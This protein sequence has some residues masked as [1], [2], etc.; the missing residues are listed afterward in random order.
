VA[1]PG[2]PEKDNDVTLRSV[3]TPSHA[4]RE[5]ASSLAGLLATLEAREAALLFSASADVALVI[6]ADGSVG[7]GVIAS[8]EL[9]ILKVDTWPGRGWSEV[10]TI[11]SRP[12]IEQMIQEAQL[13]LPPRWR[14]INHQIPNEADIPVRYCLLKAGAGGQFVA[15]GRDMRNLAAVQQRLLAAEQSIEQEYARLRHAE[16]RYRLLMQVASEAIIVVDSRS[17]RIME[18]NAAA[19]NLVSKPMKRLMG[20]Q[21][22]SLFDPADQEGVDAVM[23]ALRATG[24]AD[25]VALTLEGGKQQAV[26]SATIFRQETATCYL[27]RLQPIAAGASGIVISRAQAGVMNVIR[28]MPEPF[29]VTDLDRRIVSAN[30]AFLDSAQLGSEEQARGEPVER[31]L[32]RAGVDISV[33]FNSLAEKGAV[34]QFQTMLRGQFGAV[35]DVEV[36][37]VASP[38]GNPSCY[39]F[40]IRRVNRRATEA[41]PGKRSLLRSVEEMTKLVGKVPLKDLVREATDIIERLCI[42]AALQLND[43]NRASTADMLGLS[44]QSL[45]VK[46]HRY[47]IEDKDVGGDSA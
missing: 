10:S 26:L 46:L 36:S 2:G 39:G 27:M 11:E 38:L 25:D 35:E 34:R 47:G 43:N 20:L 6:N 18:S 30:A 21:F 7:E 41:E 8:S 22:A 3:S 28:D 17:G 1:L 33:L 40:S 45:Y 31:W 24:R 37:G 9:Q 19:A 42:E 23:G 29:V 14:Q 13:G 16:T 15:I 12:K 44:R 5:P 4:P 32:G